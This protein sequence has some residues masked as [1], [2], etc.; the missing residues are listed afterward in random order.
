MLNAA[1][2]YLAPGNNFEIAF[3]GT[4][5]TNDRWLTT[6]SINLA[7]GE[8]VGSYNRPLEWYLSARV[9]VGP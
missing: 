1:I 8:K 5:L 2:T 3:G 6:G 9:N 7:A 4:N